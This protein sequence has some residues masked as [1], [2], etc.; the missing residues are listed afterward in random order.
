MCGV[1]ALFGPEAVDAEALARLIA[2]VSRRG[3]EA[4]RTLQVSNGTLVHAAL[5]FV[6][7]GGNEQP[8]R[9][10]DGSALVWNGE[11]YNWR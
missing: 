2:V 4:T 7:V 6:D 8:H 5:R 1:A 3:P 11:I 10:R 9:G